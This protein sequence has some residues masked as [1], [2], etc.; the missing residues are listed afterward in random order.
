[1]EDLG[2]RRTRSRVETL[3]SE[4]LRQAVLAWSLGKTYIPLWYKVLKVGENGL[5]KSVVAGFVLAVATFGLRVYTALP[6]IPSYEMAVML[7]QHLD[8]ASVERERTQKLDTKVD[9]IAA[10]TADAVAKASEAAARAAETNV[11]VAWLV[12]REEARGGVRMGTLRDHRRSLV[13]I[14]NGGTGATR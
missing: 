2:R 1:M 9:L 11:K 14:A 12:R 3:P 7:K 8:E 6:R 10:R 5:V 13:E 4:E